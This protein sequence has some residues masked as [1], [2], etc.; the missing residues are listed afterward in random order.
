MISDS[1]DGY[2]GGPP[3]ELD[4]N[5]LEKYFSENTELLIC[6]D[7]SNK[8]HCRIR[9]FQVLFDIYPT[10]DPVYYSYD[11]FIGVFGTSPFFTLN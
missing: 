8:S 3:K 7:G 1:E 11:L 4:E 9:N 5:V 6:H 10:P 2:L